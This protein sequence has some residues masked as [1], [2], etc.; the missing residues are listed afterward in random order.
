MDY[1]LLEMPI[2]LYL[3]MVGGV[4]CPVVRLEQGT[5]QKACSVT[6]KNS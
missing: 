6:E 5:V 1:I 4:S 3:Q 2:G